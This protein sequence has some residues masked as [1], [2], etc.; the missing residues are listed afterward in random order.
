MLLLLLPTLALAQGITIKSGAST[1][2]ATV[3]T[4]KNLRTNLGPSTRQSFTATS[5]VL[6]TTAIYSLS[7]EAPAGNGIK[8]T[9]ICVG[10]SIGATAAGTIVLTNINRR[11]TA[12][13]GGTALTNNGSGTD[14]VTDLNGGAIAYGGVARRSATLGTIGASIDAWSFRQSVLAA[15]TSNDLGPPGHVICKQYGQN[16]EQAITVPSGATNGIS[17]VVGAGGAGSV[18]VGSIQVTFISE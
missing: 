16:G 2:T 7:I 3:D 6:T 5:S 9:Q 14:A 13:A 12:S 18:A 11:T 17:V 1:D 8:I 15:T 4:S 10:Y